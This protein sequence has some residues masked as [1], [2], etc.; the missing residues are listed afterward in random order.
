MKPGPPVLL[1]T[2]PQQLI[3]NRGIHSQVH[4]THRFSI[5][6][7]HELAGYSP[8]T[9]SLL[10]GSYCFRL[11][12]I[13]NRNEALT[14]LDIFV[15]YFICLFLCKGG[16]IQY[17]KCYQYCLSVRIRRLIQAANPNDLIHS[18]PPLPEDDRFL[19]NVASVA[20]GDPRQCQILPIFFFPIYMS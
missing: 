6:F 13:I 15:F 4:N 14:D 20:T 7:S 17:M 19:W 11:Y 3:N 8:K 2:I 5:R 16:K 9:E 10:W 18:D 1:L 12:C